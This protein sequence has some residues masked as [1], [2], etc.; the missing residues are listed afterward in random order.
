MR[1]ST[2]AKLSGAVILLSTLSYPAIAD[3]DP[4]PTPLTQMDQFKRD[5]EVFNTAVRERNQK[6]RNINQ[7]FNSAIKKAR[8]DAKIAMQSALKPDEKSSVN[9]NLKS[10]ITA[11]IIARESAIESLG[12]PPVAPIEPPKLQKG[13]HNAKNGNEK[14]RR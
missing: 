5:R 13:V 6:I 2:V 12:E 4:T 1:R 8:L 9:A 3:V 10:E 11:A 14:S 7:I